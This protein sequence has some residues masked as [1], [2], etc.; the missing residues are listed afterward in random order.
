MLTVTTTTHYE[1]AIRAVFA[2]DPAVAKQWHVAA[3]CTLDEAVAHTVLALKTADDDFVF[4]EI[5]DGDALVG[6]FG[7]EE[8]YNY[9]PT[10]GLVK[11]ARTHKNKLA[12][13]GFFRKFT[14]A[15]R[16][17]GVGANACNAPVLRF[18]NGLPEL[19]RVP[20]MGAHFIYFSEPP[21]LPSS[22][23]A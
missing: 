18:L 5:H 11:S 1:P 14:D 22:L 4:Y 2:S 6:Y 15:F 16:P 19:E 7:V 23:Q 21:C 13:V 8:N 12:L 3:P 9:L 10:F 20:F 17:Y